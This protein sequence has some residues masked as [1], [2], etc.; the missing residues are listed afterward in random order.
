[1]ERH[2]VVQRIQRVFFG[3]D[4]QDH[5]PAWLVAG[6]KGGGGVRIPVVK[7]CVRCG[8]K[9]EEILTFAHYCQICSE[10][11]RVFLRAQ[12]YPAKT[13]EAFAQKEGARLNDTMQRRQ[14]AANGGAA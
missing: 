5:P 1:M 14:D 2:V 8:R 9:Y 11:L 10:K 7:T 12:R 6:R 13:L 3:K 4:L